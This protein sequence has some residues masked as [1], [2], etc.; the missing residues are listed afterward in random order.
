MKR[1]E[2]VT[3]SKCS[4]LTVEFSRVQEYLLSKYKMHFLAVFYLTSFETAAFLLL[5]TLHLGEDYGATYF[6]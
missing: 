3:V 1:N 2:C 6:T 5:D 4:A